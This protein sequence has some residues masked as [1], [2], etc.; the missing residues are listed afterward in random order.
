MMILSISL[1][2]L[3]LK[4]QY[5]DALTALPKS[6]KHYYVPNY[7]VKFYLIVGNIM[8]QMKFF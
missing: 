1:Q 2:K 8:S 4:K 3:Y 6:D 7:I 5:N